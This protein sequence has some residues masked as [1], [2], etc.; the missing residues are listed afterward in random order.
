[1][2]TDTSGLENWRNSCSLDDDV[3]NDDNSNDDYYSGLWSCG[4]IEAYAQLNAN[5]VLKLWLIKMLIAVN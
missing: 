1:V 3:I 2:L 4:S 5:I